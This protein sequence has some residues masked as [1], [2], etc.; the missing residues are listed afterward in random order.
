MTACFIFFVIMFSFDILET[1]FMGTYNE[2][3]AFWKN[4][5]LESVCL[6]LIEVSSLYC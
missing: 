3:K 6:D 2:S 1:S 4:M 5:C